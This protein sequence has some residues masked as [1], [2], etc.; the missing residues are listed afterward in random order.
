M[1]RSSVFGLLIAFVSLSF[2]SDKQPAAAP[3]VLFAVLDGGKTIEPFAKIQDNKLV[4]ALDADAGPDAAE[5]FNDLYYQ[6]KTI[7]HLII[8]GKDKGKVAIVKS[9]QGTECGANTAQVTTSSSLVKL[10]ASDLALAT[11]MVNSKPASGL[12][13]LP[14]P[15]E[16]LAIEKLVSEEFKSYKV[17]VSGM[18]MVKLTGVD[19]AN[20]KSNQWVGTYSV[21][22]AA[23]KRGLLFFIA[24]KNSNGTYSISYSSFQLV[25]KEEVMSADIKDVDGG[26]Y[27]EVLLDL[28]DIDGDGI[29]EIFTYTPSFEGAGFKAYKWEDNKWHQVYEISNYH[30]AF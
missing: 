24:V 13:K 25:K 20:N 3:P 10:K 1:L 8:G 29:A 17:P 12:R 5:E 11:N 27:Q 16:K 22:P 2:V 26:I 14:T 30:C 18:K 23:D 9:N 28:I 19:A 15:A 4:P 6:P 7:Y 21:A